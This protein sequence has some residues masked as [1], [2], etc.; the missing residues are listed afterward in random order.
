MITGLALLLTAFL[1]GGVWGDEQKTVEKVFTVTSGGTLTLD[2][3]LG[4]VDI[5]SLPGNTVKVSVLFIADAR[6]Q[7]KA[8]RIFSDFDLAFNQSGGNVEI[9]GEYQGW[10]GVRGLF[11]HDRSQ[12]E[13]EF[14]ITVPPQYNLNIETAGGNLSVGDLKG[15]VRLETSGGNIH[16][17]RIEGKLRGTTSGG[18]IMLT[19]CTASADLVTSGGNIIVEEVDGPI[20]ARTSGGNVTIR[21]ARGSVDASTSGG[22]ISAFIADQPTEDCRLETSGGN[23]EVY[24]ASDISVDID[25]EANGGSLSTD[26]SVA[27]RGEI[28]EGVL[29][30]AINKG[31]PELRLRT[32]GGNVRLYE[33]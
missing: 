26:F 28:G 29:R 19:R 1:T 13:V 3:D 23:V 14:T 4:S 27:M 24:L 15:T 10:Q 17:E 2:T 11:G 8:Q 22:N 20:V 31:G 32:S 16:L 21:E 33:K 25:A 18:D 12:L 6:N 5:Q 7:E 30:G 9:T